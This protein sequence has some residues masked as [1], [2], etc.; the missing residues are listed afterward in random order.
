MSQICSIG[1]YMRQV[2]NVRKYA[3]SVGENIYDYGVLYR[4]GD[5]CTRMVILRVWIL[6]YTLSKHTHL[7]F[8]NILHE[9]MHK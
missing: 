9:T 7:W 4:Y 5:T 3:Y 2:I 8:Y 1:S 6:T